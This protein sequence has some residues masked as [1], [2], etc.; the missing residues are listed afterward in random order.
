M[1]SRGKEEGAVKHRG[2]STIRHAGYKRV[3]NFVNRIFTKHKGFL[4]SG[5]L[6][7]T[8]IGNKSYPT[9][10]WAGEWSFTVPCLLVVRPRSR[11]ILFQQQILWR[12]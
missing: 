6:N 9:D 1:V 10:F 7:T 3:D 8:E 5:F 2:T 12:Q 11:E 4:S